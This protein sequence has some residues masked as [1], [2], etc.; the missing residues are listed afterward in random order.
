MDP[1]ACLG[2]PPVF[3]MEAEEAPSDESQGLAY[4]LGP[5]APLRDPGLRLFQKVEDQPA[6]TRRAAIWAG[7]R[8][9]PHMSRSTNQGSDAVLGAMLCYTSS[10]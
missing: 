5:S 8:L 9:W 1:K 7:W 2:E 6:P 3:G 4:D 10:A